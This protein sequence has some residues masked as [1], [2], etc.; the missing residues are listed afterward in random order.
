MLYVLYI[1]INY[2][3]P[4]TIQYLFSFYSSSKKEKRQVLKCIPSAFSI[5]LREHRMLHGK[6][7]GLELSFSRDEARAFVQNGNSFGMRLTQEGFLFKWS[8]Q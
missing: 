6:E 7:T 1:Y 5:L 2:L 3:K 8:P 4:M